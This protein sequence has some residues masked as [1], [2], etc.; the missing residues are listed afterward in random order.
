MSSPQVFQNIV[1]KTVVEARAELQK[2]GYSLRV[3]A[4][5]GKSFPVT[6]DHSPSRVNVAVVRGVVETVS[7]LG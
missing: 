4:E 2:L 7:G 6:A 5:D 1:G 3:I